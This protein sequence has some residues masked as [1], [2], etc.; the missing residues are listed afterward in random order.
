MAKRARSFGRHRARTTYSGTHYYTRP[1]YNADLPRSQRLTTFSQAQIDQ[2]YEDGYLVLDGMFTE[3]LPALRTDIEQL[4][5]NLA[6]KLH[7]GGLVSSTYADKSWTERLLALQTETDAAIQLIKG[8]ILPPAFRTLYEDPRILDVAAQLGVGKDC[9]VSP[10]W[11]IRAK[12]PSHDETVV[13][14]HCDNSYWEP[15]IWGDHVIT[16]WVA[17]VDVD[18]SNGALLALA[19]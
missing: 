12:M 11:N 7:E 9:A 13:A 10:A 3:Q 8:G 4:I 2:Y 6:T 15:R 5:S 1:T 19:S 18:M 17:L 14:W 16:C